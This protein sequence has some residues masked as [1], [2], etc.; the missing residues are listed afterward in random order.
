MLLELLKMKAQNHQHTINPHIHL[1][2]TRKCLILST[3]RDSCEILSE[4][5][6]DFT[7]ELLDSQ[8]KVRKLPG[9]VKTSSLLESVIMKNLNPNSDMKLIERINLLNFLFNFCS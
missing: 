3:M 1:D 7:T 2:D 5:L 6:L 8:V 4:P 9:G